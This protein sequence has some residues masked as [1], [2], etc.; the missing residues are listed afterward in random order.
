MA[1][2]ALKRGL[3][4]VAVGKGLIYSNALQM[5]ALS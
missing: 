1:A 4:V 3:S 2:T 5:T